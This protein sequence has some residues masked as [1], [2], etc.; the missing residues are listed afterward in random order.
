[1]T[2]S[3]DILT[4]IL[5]I[6]GVLG[7]LY[8]LFRT[9]QAVVLIC[10]STQANKTELYM[11]LVLC[12]FIAGFSLAISGIAVLVAILNDRQEEYHKMELRNG[13]QREIIEQLYAERRKWWYRNEDG[14]VVVEPVE[15]DFDEIFT[16]GTGEA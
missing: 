9:V 8:G 16:N 7:F 13:L 10:Q 11:L 15:T 5:F 2:K 3:K 14:Q 12:I 4:D 1:M 6:A